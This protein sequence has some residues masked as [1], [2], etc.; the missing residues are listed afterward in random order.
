MVSAGLFTLTI[1][2]KRLV[3]KGSTG[4]LS[5]VINNLKIVSTVRVSGNTLM[6]LRR[7]NESAIQY[8]KSNFDRSD[9]HFSLTV[10]KIVAVVLGCGTCSGSGTSKIEGIVTVVVGIHIATAT[11]ISGHMRIWVSE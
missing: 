10:R 4:S 9:K 7:V 1:L 2:N 6:P 3:R 8:C 11:Y 5:V